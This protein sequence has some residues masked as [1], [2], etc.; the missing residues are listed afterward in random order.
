MR[1]T[2]LDLLRFLAAGAVT[3]YH[4]SDFSYGY[5][6]VNF[7]FILSGFVIL[8]SAQKANWAYFAISRFSR[9]Y[10]T[11]WLCMA[12]T[13]GY[14]LLFTDNSPALYQIAANGTMLAGYLGVDYIDGVYWTLQLELKF[15]A[16]IFILILS[17]QMSRIE[18]WLWVWLLAGTA[19]EYSD[20]LAS[21]TLHPYHSYFIGG[22]SLFLIW[23]KGID[24]KR[25]ALSA[26]CGL[27]ATFHA[28]TQI[29][30]FIH[31]EHI[32]WVPSVIVAGMFLLVFAIAL[33]WIRFDHSYWVTLGTISYPL[34]LLHNTI[35]QEH[36]I[37]ALILTIVV[38]V[39]ADRPMHRSAR[40]FLTRSYRR[41]FVAV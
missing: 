14:L 9:V 1:L 30:H 7:F 21:L 15:Y 6:G 23:S 3:L 29:G 17:G 5:L 20:F 26:T 2:E 25:L 36:V 32:W 13:I 33:R 8:W 27:V 37:A 12:I 31:A 16:L 11:F 39:Y 38:A 35:G 40:N 28:Y 18:L 22:C 10:P 19:G 24:A 41:A 34:Y 4:L